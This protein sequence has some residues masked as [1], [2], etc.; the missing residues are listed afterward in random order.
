MARTYHHGDLKRALIDAGLEL[1]DRGGVEAVSVRAAARVVGVSHAAPQRHFPDLQA[2]LAAIAAACYA[3]LAAEMEEATLRPQTPLDRLRAAGLAYVSFAASR[4]NRFKALTHPLIEPRSAHPDLAAA[5][6][7]AFA[8]L[9]SAIS[10]AQA[11]GAL[12]KRDGAVVALAAWSTVHGLAALVVDDQLRDKG[13]DSTPLELAEK[14]L[15]QFG[16]G[17]GEGDTA[18][19]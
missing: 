9:E 14:V 17:L 16:M 2:F 18:R 11:D 10:E 6:A 13:Y 7:K 4:P 1:L 19:A 15:E 5:S 8:V 12:A 3:Q